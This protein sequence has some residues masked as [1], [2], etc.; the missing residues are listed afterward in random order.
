MKTEAF[1]AHYNVVSHGSETSEPTCMT[2]KLVPPVLF[3]DDTLK[4]AEGKVLPFLV[5]IVLSNNGY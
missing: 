4:R 2:S 5:C 1:K 3:H